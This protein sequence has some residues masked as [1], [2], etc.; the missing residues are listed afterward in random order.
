L[1]VNKHNL[2]PGYF[3]PA[4]ARAV[5]T[6]KKAEKV[7]LTVKPQC[8]FLYFRIQTLFLG[9]PHFL[10]SMSFEFSYFMKTDGFGEKGRPAAGEEG[11]VP[12]NSTLLI[13]LEL[14][15]WKTVTEIGDDKKI[16]KKVLKEG[17]GYERPN[18][19]AVVKGVY[20]LAKPS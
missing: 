14:I 5:K 2:L 19:G 7:L 15:S 6:M 11:V 3:C 13:D 8:K 4:L 12:P 18:E 10:L 9:T 1:F 17:E 16:L 20:A